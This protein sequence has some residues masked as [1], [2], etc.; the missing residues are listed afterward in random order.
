MGLV[1]PVVARQFVLWF[2]CAMSC[3]SAARAMA[4][5][6]AEQLRFMPSTHK[7]VPPTATFSLT[8]WLDGVK[9]LASFMTQPPELA[10]AT[11]SGGVDD[12]RWLH[13]DAVTSKH[14]AWSFTGHLNLLEDTALALHRWKVWWSIPRLLRG[15]RTET[16]VPPETYLYL[17]RAATG[18]YVLLLP[19]VDR[20]MGFTLEGAKSYDKDEVKDEVS[21]DLNGTV[22]DGCRYLML[23]GHDISLGPTS[24]DQ[25]ATRSRKAL[26]VTTGTD[27][28]RLIAT[29]VKMVKRHMQ[30]GLGQRSAQE[31][32]HN[33]N[34]D[35][36]N[37]H[38]TAGAAG[39]AA[40]AAA[41]SSAS[42]RGTGPRFADYFGWCSWDSF[43]TDLSADGVLG[44]LSSFQGTGVTPRFLILDDGWQG[45][46]VDD[47]A[48]SFQWGGRLT[49]FDA[50][51]KF[52]ETYDGFPAPPT[53]ESGAGNVATAVDESD[54]DDDDDD[55]D[56]GDDE[57]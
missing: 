30:D 31:V 17:A 28:F 19:V 37:A 54:D 15:A 12:A 47:Q 9:P 35:G 11:A 48:N 36:N 38:A 13:V 20:N 27:P 46:T 4:R 22:A 26:L 32:C 6:S 25:D 14:Q 57:D 41:L 10:A 8:A 49:S 29:S 2:Y 53:T 45:T 43:Y 3:F 51:F 50:N 24:I 52:E 34:D 40:A 33:N 21:V 23:H 39:A 7:N 42:P 44:G 1:V 5:Y 55:D 16:E 18:A 56:D